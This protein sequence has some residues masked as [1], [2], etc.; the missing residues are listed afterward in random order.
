MPWEVITGAGDSWAVAWL[1]VDDRRPGVLRVA[2]TSAPRRG[3]TKGMVLL[4]R[5]LEG[6]SEGAKRA[7][8]RAITEVTA[9]TVYTSLPAM[10][11][12]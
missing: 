10:N 3:G 1:R 8:C 11:H 4:E 12:G 9:S 7:R 5:E 6:P 2:G